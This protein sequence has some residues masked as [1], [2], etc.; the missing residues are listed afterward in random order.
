MRG[1]RAPVSLFVDEVPAVQAYFEAFL[2]CDFAL[3][4]VFGRGST[5]RAYTHVFLRTMDE[6]GWSP[7]PLAMAAGSACPA[8][9][10]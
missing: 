10:R 8:V 1:R 6:K 5:I 3:V 2:P 4:E 7:A 9:A